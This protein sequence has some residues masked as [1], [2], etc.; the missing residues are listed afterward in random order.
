MDNSSPPPADA[1]GYEPGTPPPEPKTWLTESIVLTSCLCCPFGLVALFY[2]S[3]VENFY[4]L[5]E[6]DRAN[7]YSR[8]ARIWALWGFAV[9]AALLLVLL[10]G[11]VCY[12]IQNEK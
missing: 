6:Y 7:A 8:K 11:L 1:A 10:I 12:W 5:G 2:A 4:L 3:K 9:A